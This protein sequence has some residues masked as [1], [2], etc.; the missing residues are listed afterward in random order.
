M[1][2]SKAFN[3]IPHKLLNAKFKAYGV[4]D[5]ACSLL[6]SYFR[7][8]QQRVK[9]GNV[10]SEWENVLKGSAQGSVN[11]PFSFNNFCNDMLSLVDPYVN[12]YNYAD[13]NTIMYSGRYKIKISE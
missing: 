5:S 9:I 10:T 11:G 13:N 2:L 7:D 6:L 12:I 1:D 8:R 3:C 4:S